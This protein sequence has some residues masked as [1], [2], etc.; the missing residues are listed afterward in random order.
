M[1]EDLREMTFK[2]LSVADEYALSKHED[3][4]MHFQMSSD[5]IYLVSG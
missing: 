1:P 3:A 5:T 4:I 2:V